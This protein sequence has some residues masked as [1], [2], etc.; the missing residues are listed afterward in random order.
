MVEAR[1]INVLLVHP[2]PAQRRSLADRLSSSVHIL[3]FSTLDEAIALA[4]ACRPDAVAIKLRHNR[5]DL[6]LLEQWAASQPAVPLLLMR[7]LE[8]K[9][10]A[11][12]AA[13]TER[14]SA[15]PGLE[16]VLIVPDDNPDCLLIGLHMLLA[17][18]YLPPAMQA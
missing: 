12:G 4:S 3:P 11:G 6:R 5:D 1:K 18:E 9:P 10:E 8:E 7:E 13:D 16:R 15:M 2:D 14:L 17:S